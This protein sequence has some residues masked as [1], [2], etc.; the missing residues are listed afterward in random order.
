[1]PYPESQGRTYVVRTFW[2]SPETTVVRILRLKCASVLGMYMETHFHQV[3]SGISIS[4]TPTESTRRVNHG[5]RIRDTHKRYARCRVHPLLAVPEESTTL[6]RRVSRRLACCGR[7]V[8]T[9]AVQLSCC[10]NWG[11]AWRFSVPGGI[12]NSLE[13]SPYPPVDGSG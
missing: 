7:P 10:C 2:I 6:T 3:L 11:S 13:F 5:A 8:G 1:M 4:A 12:E 9:L